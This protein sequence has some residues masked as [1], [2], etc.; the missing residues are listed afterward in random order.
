MKLLNFVSTVLLYSTSFLV[1]CAPAPEAKATW[2][3][4]GRNRV[5]PHDSRHAKR[6]YLNS[7]AP[8][9]PVC[10]DAA[11]AVTAPVPN[12]WEGFT[13]QE[14]ASVAYWLFE[15]SNLNLTTTEEAGEWDN[16]V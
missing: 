10:G 6:Q 8:Q 9:A 5:V 16:S 1:A 13:N 15:Q 3:K 12:V 4:S 11:A 7:T 2:V 14:A